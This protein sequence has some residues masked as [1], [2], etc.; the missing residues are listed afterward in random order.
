MSRKSNKIFKK[1]AYIDRFK[2][3]KYN[4]AKFRKVEIDQKE[5]Q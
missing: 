2:G 4:R 3:Y 1:F 5:R